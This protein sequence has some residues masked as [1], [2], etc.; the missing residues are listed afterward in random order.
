LTPFPFNKSYHKTGHFVRFL[1][2][3]MKLWG[4]PLVRNRRPRRPFR[5]GRGL[6][7]YRDGQTV[8]GEY[9]IL[10][11]A[12]STQSRSSRFCPRSTVTIT[13][14]PQARLLAI[15]NDAIWAYLL[16]GPQ[17]SRNLFN[18]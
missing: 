1:L 3:D 11:S 18:G 2:F 15:L 17:S 13:P 4:G 10:M 5:G 7:S 14:L 8:Q 6:V 12:F 16:F 9:P